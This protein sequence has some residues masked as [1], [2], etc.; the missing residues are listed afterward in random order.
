MKLGEYD[1]EQEGETKDQTFTLA[2][3]KI[4][5]NYDDVSFE[6]DIAIL[7]LNGVATKSE[8]VWPICLPPPTEKFTNRRAFVIGQFDHQFH[9]T[10]SCSSFLLSSHSMSQAG[11]PSTSAAL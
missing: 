10:S 2:S 3:M 1:F 9:N 4:H 6:N 11:A 5:E 8:S 7:K